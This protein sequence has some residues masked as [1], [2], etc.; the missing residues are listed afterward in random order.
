MSELNNKMTNVEAKVHVGEAINTLR[1]L[2]ELGYIGD[3]VEEYYGSYFVEDGETIVA[4]ANTL[5]GNE[6]GVEKRDRAPDMYAALSDVYQGDYKLKIWTLDTSKYPAF[7]RVSVS[8]GEYMHTFQSEKY[9]KRAA[10]IILRRVNASVAEMGHEHVEYF[11]DEAKKLQAAQLR[12][13]LA[14]DIYL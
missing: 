2:H 3:E 6:L 11:V 8:R 12:Y 7:V 10:E 4:H 13:E 5:M 1:Y 14:T 9:S